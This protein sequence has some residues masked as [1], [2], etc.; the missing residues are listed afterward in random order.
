LRFLWYFVFVAAIAIAV[1]TRVALAVGRDDLLPMLGGLAI[2][3]CGGCFVIGVVLSIRDFGGMW[4]VGLGW[5]TR[6]SHPFTYWS[7]LG[8]PLG[9]GLVLLATGVYVLVR[10]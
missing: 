10:A 5:I 2:A 6:R 4:V 3:L 9:L 8:L 1:A 7:V